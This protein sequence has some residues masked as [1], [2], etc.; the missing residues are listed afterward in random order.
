[1]VWAVCVLA[2]C[3]TRTVYDKYEHTPIM[4]WEK[5]DSLF[6]TTNAVEKG[7]VYRQEL[8]LRI[9]GAYPFMSL[10]LIVEQELMPEHRKWRDTVDYHLTDNK[11]NVMGQG[12][13][14][15]Q[16][17]LPVGEVSME[18]GDSLHI[19][20]HHD[21]KRGILPGI[22]DIGIKISRKH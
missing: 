19:N 8:G 13:S 21:M 14:Y 17:V 2:A 10:R 11:G 18:A 6:F 15:Y 9:N 22:S 20:V 16:Y 3:D 12:T 5:N 4:G 7:G 1:M